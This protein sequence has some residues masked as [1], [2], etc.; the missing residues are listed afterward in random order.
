MTAIKR[1]N[2]P[3]ALSTD[4][5]VEVR[6]AEIGGD[7]SVD[8]IRLPKGKDMAPSLKGLP[9]DMCQTPHWGVISSG[10]LLLRTK[11]GSETYE[12]GDAFYWEPGHAPEALEDTEFMDFTPTGEFDTVIDHVKAQLG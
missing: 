2:T 8:Y 12:S 7:M 9:D 1:G 6:R 11:H 10:K 4:D 3:V 5:G